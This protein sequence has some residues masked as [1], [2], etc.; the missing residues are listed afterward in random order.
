M[1]RLKA[2]L[3]KARESRETAAAA[4][5]GAP[6]R[7]S[8]ARRSASADV[9]PAW[10]AL[11]LLDTEPRSLARKRLVTLTGSPDAMPF[12]VL[13]TKVLQLMGANDWRRVALTSPSPGSGKTTTA[14]NLAVALARHGDLRVILFDFDM[15]R[16]GLARLL[17]APE[18][19]SMP[20]LLAGEVDFAEQARRI[21]SNLALSMN[22]ETVRESADVLL[23][24]ST[25]DCLDE[26]ERRYRPDLMIFDLP[27]MLV[28]DETQAFASCVDCA[29]LI[30][31]GSVST[32]SQI[33]MCEKDLA[34]Q[35]NVLGVVLNKCRFASEGSAYY[36]DY[37]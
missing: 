36:Y 15:R 9:G 3:D 1:E 23:R 8:I 21:G 11:P 7:V 19:P 14:F 29:I 28:G 25:R 33:D 31:E 35:T 5:A 32:T 4:G 2:A 16:P 20:R 27:P 37:S 10:E 26:I 13:R 17:D 22:R 30:A 12:D 34:E 6:P 24:R 18:V